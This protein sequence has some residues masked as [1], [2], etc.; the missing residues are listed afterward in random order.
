MPQLSQLPLLEEEA[1]CSHQRIWVL[2]L[3]SVGHPKLD[4]LH[5]WKCR[6]SLL[7]KDWVVDQSVLGINLPLKMVMMMM[8]TNLA[9]DLY[10]LLWRIHGGVDDP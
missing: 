8:S 7:S 3:L 1:Q 2:L 10:F 4:F 9:G 5:H 6:I